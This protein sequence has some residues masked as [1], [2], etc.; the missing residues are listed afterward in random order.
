MGTSW[1]VDVTEILARLDSMDS[2]AAQ[3]DAAEIGRIIADARRIAERLRAAFT[4]IVGEAGRSAA[5]S[6]RAGTLLGRDLDAALDG[7]TTGHDALASASGHLAAAS[8]LRP[9]VA[10][11]P[12]LPPVTP[13]AALIVES[14][15]TAI[16]SE[17]TAGYN[18][19]MAGAADGLAAAPAV[20]LS[21][22][23]PNAAA[24]RADPAAGVAGH[25][26]DLPDVSATPGP[27]PGGAVGTDPASGPASAPTAPAATPDPAGQAVRSPSVAGTP[28]S[29]APASSGPGGGGP[30]PAPSAVPVVPAT[31]MRGRPVSATA[32]PAA[33]TS[34][35]ARSGGLVDRLAAL[36]RQ[37]PPGA[38][39]T[40]AP[41][42]DATESVTR[43]P[44][45]RPSGAGAGTPYG[46][47]GTRGA[48][49][50]GDDRSRRRPA[51]YLSSADE[52]V[53]VLGP[54][55]WVVPAVIGAVE[56]DDGVDGDGDVADDG[57]S[58]GDCAGEDGAGDA[59]QRIDPTL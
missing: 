33:S 30:A 36:R 7:L 31:G 21:N 10:A 58:A 1:M 15:R 42:A 12:D 52:G 41:P 27:T 19:P 32:R 48:P 24:L 34:P 20:T 50:A 25:A 49:G 17:L 13:A 8:A 37:V 45:A 26:R 38:S 51:A 40:Q 23:V 4:P 47:A 22:G 28:E 2:A 39:T 53:L 3:A 14:L 54:Q 55:P 56:D 43:R 44:A 9:R 6:S 18:V 35:V 5:E 46:P 29:G 11:I 59:E 16:A 57:P